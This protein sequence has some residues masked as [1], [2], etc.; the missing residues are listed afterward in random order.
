MHQM[1]SFDKLINS[2]LF[3]VL[4]HDIILFPFEWEFVNDVWPQ[5]HQQG[6]ERK[7]QQPT[8]RQFEK[9]SY[10]IHVQK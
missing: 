3:V 9:F 8:T 1:D 6:D 2:K 4:N 10:S 7:K 5:I